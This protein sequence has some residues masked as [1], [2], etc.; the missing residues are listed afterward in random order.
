MRG[1]KSDSGSLTALL[2]TLE[3]TPAVSDAVL[4]AR[5][6]ETFKQGTKAENDWAMRE[7]MRSVA[8]RDPDA[9]LRLLGDATGKDADQNR[10][11]ALEAF[12]HTG[13]A[14]RV[15]DWGIAQIQNFSTDEWKCCAESELAITFATTRPDLANR[16]YNDA[17]PLLVTA[18]DPFNFARM[19]AASALLHRGDGEG[20]MTRLQAMNVEGWLGSEGT[21]R[22]FAMIGRGDPAQAERKSR[23]L[24]KKHDPTPTHA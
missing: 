3:T 8:R 22:L 7:L 12:A 2:L 13:D 10:F 1:G 14:A 5:I 19:I 6:A 21:A 18:T 4:L 20:M 15:A 17:L 23:N 9:A 16:F 11:A 24:T